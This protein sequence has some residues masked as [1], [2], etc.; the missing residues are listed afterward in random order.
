MGNLFPPLPRTGSRPTRSRNNKNNRTPILSISDFFDQLNTLILSNI[1]SSFNNIRILLNTCKKKLLKDIAYSII[2]RENFTY[3]E[4]REQWYL[5]ISDIIET[6]LWKNVTPPEKVHLENPCI[7]NFS[8][9]GFNRLT[10]SKIFRSPD[11]IASLPPELQ[12]EIKVPFPTY[13]LDPPIRNKIFNYKEAIN[14]IHVDIDEDIS[15]IHNLPP[16]DCPSSPFCDPHHMHIITGDLRIIENQKL[17]YLFSK[18]PN[19]REAKTFNLTKCKESVIISLDVTIIKLAEKYKL[20]RNIF[21]T[22]KNKIISKNNQ[23]QA[24]IFSLLA[25]M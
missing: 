12:S 18:G 4:G 20:D 5:L 25:S 24:T 1:K 8:N 21:T 16:C 10:L 9:K 22:W 14:S 11:V 6:L 2:E 23:T 3:I 17:R 15:I 19:Y 13:K 7:I